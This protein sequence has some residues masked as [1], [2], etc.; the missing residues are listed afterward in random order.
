MEQ[1]CFTLVLE[2]KEASAMAERGEGE[3]SS[4]RRG[5]RWLLCHKMVLGAVYNA[6]VRKT[7]QRTRVQ[8]K[9]IDGQM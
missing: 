5:Y 4:E 6:L 9:H 8:V 1:R 2:E 3:T 7:G